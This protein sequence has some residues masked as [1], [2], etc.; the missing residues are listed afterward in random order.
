MPPRK[1]KLAAL[2]LLVVASEI[3]ANTFNNQPKSH[4]LGWNECFCHWC[5]V[6]T[7]RLLQP[8]LRSSQVSQCDQGMPLNRWNSSEVL[9]FEFIFRGYH[10]YKDMLAAAI[11]EVLLCHRRKNFR[12]KIIFV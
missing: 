5:T 1:I 3:F 4:Y 2:R 6:K 10:V 7:L 12:C 8:H 9:L 11:G